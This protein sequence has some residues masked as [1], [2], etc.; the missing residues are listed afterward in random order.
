MG[1]LDNKWISI[2]HLLPP[3]GILVE[4]KIE[5]QHGTRNEQKLVRMGNLMFNEDR[6][7]YVYYKPTHW[8]EIKRN[9][10]YA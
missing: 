6:K 8:R 4:T 7:T 2:D 1:Y 10:S 3:E 5:D 9:Y